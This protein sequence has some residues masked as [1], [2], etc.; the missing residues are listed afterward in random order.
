MSHDMSFTFTVGLSVSPSQESDTLGFDAHALH[1]IVVRIAEYFI[2]RNAR[3]AFGHDWRED[4]VMRAIAGYAQ[5]AVALGSL[6]GPDHKQR[7]LNLVPTKGKPVSEQARDAVAYGGGTLEVLPIHEAVEQPIY[8]PGF[9]LPAGWADNR[10]TE[11]WVLR[12]VLTELLAPGLRI[13]LGG[14][15]K[16]SGGCYSGIA[17]EAFFA[18]RSNKPLFL[19][20]AFGGAT[21]A[22]WLA[23]NGKDSGLLGRSEAPAADARV[24][25]EAAKK[26]RMPRNGLF[27]ALQRMG[28]DTYCKNAGLT[29][30]ESREL[31]KVTDIEEALSLIDGCRHRG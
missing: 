2:G 8:C 6:A 30:R 4:G 9:E 23:L 5:A 10:I 29:A 12:S 21:E 18:L 26:C 17:E 25:A 27:A 11:L 19:L 24:V 15:T 1:R 7:L 16:G 28:L 31:A 3:V 13:C 22:V 20:P 14:R